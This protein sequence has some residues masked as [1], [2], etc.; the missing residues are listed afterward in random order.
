MPA[1]PANVPTQ[2]SALMKQP[3]VA[4]TVA[5]TVDMMRRFS[6]KMTA[7][8]RQQQEM[9]APPMVM[10][11][12]PQV[13]GD[14]VAPK[15]KPWKRSRAVRIAMRR[16]DRGMRNQPQTQKIVI[17][18]PVAVMLVLVIFTSSASA[19]GYG[20][21]ESQLPNLQKIANLR[22]SQTT[23]IYDRNGVLLTEAYD[24]NSGGRR[25]PVAYKDVPK[26]MQD[27]MT[28]A[29]DPTF[30][31][32]SGIDPQG[33]TRAATSYISHQG[34]IA[35][36]GSTLTQQV[37]KNTTGDDQQTIN[38]KIPEAALAIGLTQQYPKWKVLEMYF[39]VAGFASQD[40][41]VE[42]A[43]EEF[44]GLKPIC[45][46]KFNCKPGISQLSYN[47]TTKKN[48]PLL[49]LARASLL[50]GMPQ[51]PNSYD[52]TL[53]ESHKKL[54]LARQDYVLN[55]MMRSHVS[56]EG[57]GQITPK[58][59]QDAEA[60]SAKMTFK[61]YQAFKK[62]PHFTDWIKSQ[63]ALILGDGNY[64]QGAGML[65]TGGFNIRTSID[66]NVETYV[67][68]AVKRH[69]TQA[70]LQ[71]FYG[72]YVVPKDY[73]NLN[74]AAVVVM[75]AKTGEIL[76]MDG[77]LD[78]NNNNPATSGQINMATTP[79][80]PGSTFKPIDYSTTFEMGL[81]PGTVLP[82]FETFFPNGGSA[83]MTSQ[84]AYHPTDYNN[85]FN[86]QNSTIRMATANSFNIPAV[87]AVSFAGV[88]NVANTARRMG[89][90]D[91]DSSIATLKK[92]GICK[93]DATVAQCV[94]MTIALGSVEISPLQMTGAYQVLANGGKRVPPQ[95]ILDIW[96]N[97]GHNLY[98]FD[99]AHA[100]EMQV[101]TPQVA[102]MM[103]SVLT[104]QQARAFEFQNVHTLSFWDWDGVCS[105]L[106]WSGMPRCVHDVAAKTGT[107][108]DFKDNWTMGY[109]PNV[110]VG[111]WTGNANN[112]AMVNKPTGITGAGPIW[113]SVISYMTGRPCSQ[114]DPNIACPSK[115]LDRKALN[116]TQPD[117][118]AQPAG[119]EKACSNYTSTTQVKDKH[120]KTKDKTSTT[121]NC[122]WVLQGQAPVQTANNNGDNNNNGDKN[123]GDNNNG[124]NNNGDNN[125]NNNGDNG[126]NNNGNNN[127]D[128]NNN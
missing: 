122:D 76:A 67:E 10:Y 88:D 90:T 106:P 70:E 56:V 85:Q 84:A 105:T 103:T 23:R 112:S 11:H 49:G 22:I 8:N 13:S 96:D 99:P 101:L 58:V 37:I 109:T 41:G 108:D 119:L 87:K 29:E 38:R 5:N 28:S 120:G 125:N 83:G 64:T 12:S 31:T 14:L 24:P 43:V 77:S 75:N 1:G 73:Y 115:P 63:V 104:D 34:N 124:D 82:D 55:Q 97:Y 44:F 17:S 68:N 27:A 50:A 18:V 15:L 65:N 19:Y 36:G 2:F 59:V 111:V 74:D 86:N 102:Y 53:G 98:H 78:Y 79:R 35:G 42:A 9:P 61:R 51:N 81:T 33:I 114:I 60:L 72:I 7:I 16:R 92:N 127:G 71:P 100:Q 26:V 91:I 94:N 6:G 110:V 46:I 25:I 117:T 48:D 39:N 121:T 47:A 62:A 4:N 107:T 21:Y 20:Y 116:L 95:G 126:N 128:N 40:M 52:P 30:W 93:Q 45:D 80:Q 89:I 66:V 123:N 57:L 54:A 3:W 118:F 69:L 113:Q 32:N